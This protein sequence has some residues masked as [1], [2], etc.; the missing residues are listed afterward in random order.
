MRIRFENIR[1]IDFTR[2]A[3][4]LVRRLVSGLLPQRPKFGPG[5]THV[6][7]LLDR[8]AMEQVAVKSVSRIS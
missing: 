1:Y 8:V 5:A 2:Q 4:P 6:K 7:C 3:V